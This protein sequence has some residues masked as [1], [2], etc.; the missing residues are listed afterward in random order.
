MTDGAL[1]L[2]LGAVAGCVLGAAFYAGLWLTVRRV[3]TARSPRAALLLSFG[4]RSV[5]VGA[6]FVLIARQGAL[7]LL[8]ALVGFVGARPLVTWA[9]TGRP[10][11]GHGA[12]SEDGGRA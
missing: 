9:V 11:A 12:G 6:A 8:G 7:P 3:T 1:G 4:V 10:R 2:A 5:L